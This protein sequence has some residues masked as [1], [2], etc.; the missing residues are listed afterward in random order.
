MNRPDDPVMCD[1]CGLPIPGEP[2]ET[3]VNGHEYRFCSETCRAEFESRPTES[4]EYHGFKRVA[5]DVTGLDAQLPDGFPRSSFVLVS[6]ML[7]TRGDALHAELV[8]RTLRRGEPAV[9]VAWQEP[10]VSLV[11]RF[12]ALEWNVIPFLERDRLRIV[13]CFT[14]RLPA[15]R[16]H[17]HLTDWNQYV[18]DAVAESTTRI[19]DFTSLSTVRSRLEDAVEALE[20][21]DSGTVVIDSL[22]ELGVTT[23]P[24]HAMNFVK[25]LRAGLCKGR[26]VPVFAGSTYVFPDTG[27]PQTV[28]YVADGV[29]ELNAWRQNQVETTAAAG[30]APA[31]GDDYDPVA[32]TDG[33]TADDPT[34]DPDDGTTGETGD[35]RRGSVPRGTGGRPAN[36]EIDRKHVHVT[37]MR[38]VETRARPLPYEFRPGDGL[39]LLADPV[40]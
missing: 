36:G 19:T 1:T 10:P 9:V 17:R 2:V 16:E 8:W 31:G 26:D 37:H 30:V 25:D 32:D 33:G 13:D 21:Y 6:E 14:E 3:T 12:V 38:G 28:R 22:D 39:V 23:Q 35:G 34:A 15:Y 18:H 7:G 29:V 11:E 27:F 5:L 24:I 4:T 20:M 40:E